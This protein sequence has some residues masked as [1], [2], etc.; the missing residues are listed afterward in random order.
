M[1]DDVAERIPDPV[2][3]LGGAQVIQDEHL[4]LQN[5]SHDLRGRERMRWPVGFLN[6]A[7]KFPEINEKAFH[8]LGLHQLPQDAHGKVGLA[9]ATGTAEQQAHRFGRRVSGDELEGM[10]PGFQLRRVVDLVVLQLAVAIAGR[11]A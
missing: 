4:R 9:D 3:H 7:K 8:A 5:R 6:G 1:I 2:G 11:D 10:L